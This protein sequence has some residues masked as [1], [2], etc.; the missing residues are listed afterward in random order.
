MIIRIRQPNQFNYY[1]DEATMTKWISS[2]GLQGVTVAV[3]VYII[4]RMMSW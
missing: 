2:R 3:A 1:V 4:M